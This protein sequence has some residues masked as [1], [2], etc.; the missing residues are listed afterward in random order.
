[1]DAITREVKRTKID[2]I[3]DVMK[4]STQTGPIIM[5]QIS[6]LTKISSAFRTFSSE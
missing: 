2:P 1:M 6:K 5:R 3:L 4:L